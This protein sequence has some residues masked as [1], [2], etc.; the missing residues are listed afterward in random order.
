MIRV[1]NDG[2]DI[3]AMYAKDNGISLSDVPREWLNKRSIK[4][5]KRAL[6]WLRRDEG[7]IFREGV[8]I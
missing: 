1:V 5:E 8:A 2:A 6:V 3:L 7:G 4:K